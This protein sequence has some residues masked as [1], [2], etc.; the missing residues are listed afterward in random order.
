MI[1]S[2]Y[3]QEKKRSYFYTSLRIPPPQPTSKILTPE[4]DRSF[5]ADS[6]GSNPELIKQF[7]IKGTLKII[8]KKSC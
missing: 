6:R 1:V 2:K 4:R 3:L 5:E 8:I 7:L